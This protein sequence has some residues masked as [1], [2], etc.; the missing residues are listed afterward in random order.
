[1]KLS[2]ITPL[3]L[4]WNEAPNIARCLEP[5][6]GFE[7]V[8]VLDSFSTDETV[9]IARSFPNVD[10]V[11]HRFE[12]FAKQCNHG[13]SLIASEWVLSMDAD[14]VANSAFI[15]ELT[16]LD[17]S[18][19]VVG[20]SVPFRYCIAGHPLRGTIYPPRTCLYRRAAASYLDDGHGHRV[21][22]NGP[23]S[24]LQTPLAHD[25]R[26]SLSRWLSV[27]LSYAVL[28]CDKLSLASWSKLNWPDRLRRSC[29]FAPIAIL[30]Y[31][32]IFKGLILDGW[33]GWFYTLQRVFAEV[34]LA[35]HLLARRLA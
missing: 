21:H 35:L 29:I 5:L 22:L 15:A 19:G 28:E 13:L 33:R 4:T 2:A 34:L 11:Q 26:K 10:L 27:Q 12:S 16:R 17:N 30:F 6:A 9:E 23:I 3:V 18:D 8:L 20:Y 24:A 32:L 31:C 14:Y 1:M 7:R 25:D